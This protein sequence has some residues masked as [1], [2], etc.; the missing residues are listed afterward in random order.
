MNR[1]AISCEHRDGYLGRWLTETERVE[2]EA[3]LADCSDCRH[4]IQENERLDSLLARAN[5]A[6][7]PVP[8]GLLDRIDGRI[9]QARR[10]RVFAWTTGLA[11]A[12]I[13][14][15]ALGAWL[16]VPRGP[17]NRFGPSPGLTKRPHPPEPTPD[18]RSLVHV[19]FENESDVIAVPQKTDNPSVTIIWVYPTIKAAQDPSPAP[20]ELVQPSERNGI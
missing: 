12:G 1:K 18:A 10:R 15:G 2:F 14:I 13:L 4:L 16:H 8:A 9:R 3:H 11:A 5:A 19:T 7:L 20:A 17:E 6:L